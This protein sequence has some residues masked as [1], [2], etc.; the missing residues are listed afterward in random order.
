MLPPFGHQEKCGHAPEVSNCCW[1]SELASLVL[2]TI[3]VAK[4]NPPQNAGN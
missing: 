2:H 4:K 3:H 1:G